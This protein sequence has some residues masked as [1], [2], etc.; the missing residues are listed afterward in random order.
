M[1]HVFSQKRLADGYGHTIQLA[2]MRAAEN[3][4][5]KQCELFPILKAEGKKK[6]E[7]PKEPKFDVLPKR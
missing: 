7:E 4:L 2:Q 3:A 6:I 1:F 5:T